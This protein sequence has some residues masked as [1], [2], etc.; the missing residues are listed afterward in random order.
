MKDREPE[1]NENYSALTK[2]S[3][4]LLPLFSKEENLLLKVLAQIL[5]LPPKPQERHNILTHKRT[6]KMI[7]GLQVVSY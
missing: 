7:C 1:L 6:E 2:E 5:E 3:L 4:L